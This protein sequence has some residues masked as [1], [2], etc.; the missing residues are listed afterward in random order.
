M[1]DAENPNDTSTGGTYAYERD[2]LS[3]F[4]A[5]VAAYD[6]DTH[7][8][9]MGEVYEGARAKEIRPKINRMIPAVQE[10]L[11]FVGVRTVIDWTPPPT[12]GGSPQRVDVIT[13]FFNLQD[14]DM[15]VETVLDYVER[16]IGLLEHLA[17]T[18]RLPAGEREGETTGIE[19]LS[20]LERGVRQAFSSH[21]KE[22]KGDLHPIVRVV[23]G[24]LNIP[25][26]M[27]QERV[28]YATTSAIPD[29]VLWEGKVALEVKLLRDAK[30]LP[31]IT[32]EIN[33][34]ILKY[35]DRFSQKVF[36]VYDCGTLRDVEEFRRA[37]MSHRGVF[38]LV[39]KH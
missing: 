13:N 2:V 17:K 36:L 32:T 12:V 21:P 22:E 28:A 26:T 7:G 5:L 30:D 4:A 16:G 39:V 29:F 31:R 9:S 14:R 27:E 35:G 25:F 24:S 18:G 8:D 6:Q 34:D 10:I 23:L 1:S 37:F 15:G 20:G 3:E 38:V 33:D 11:A 19:L